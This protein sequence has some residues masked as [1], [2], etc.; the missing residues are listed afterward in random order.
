MRKF[1]MS[2]I[3]FKIICKIVVEY[4]NYNCELIENNYKNKITID[5]NKI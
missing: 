2:P 4:L 5:L 1:P 3:G